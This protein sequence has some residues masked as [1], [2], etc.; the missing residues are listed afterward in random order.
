M[1]GYCNGE[2]G[3]TPTAGQ[4]FGL[5]HHSCLHP[6]SPNSI[7]GP[8]E[9]IDTFRERGAASFPFYTRRPL[10]SCPALHATP[11]WPLTPISG[12]SEDPSTIH[13][14]T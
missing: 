8:C 4:N 7:P 11:G 6:G 9:L 14:S 5:H 3:V 10:P 1:V 12:A 2:V 13:S